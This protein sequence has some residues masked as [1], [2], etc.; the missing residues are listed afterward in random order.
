MMNG[1][2]NLLTLDPWVHE[3]QGKPNTKQCSSRKIAVSSMQF[4][5]RQEGLVLFLIL[6]ETSDSYLQEENNEYYDQECAFPSARWSK[7]TTRFTRLCGFDSLAQQPHRNARLQ[8]TLVQFTVYSNAGYAG[9]EPACV[10]GVTRRSKQQTSWESGVSLIGNEWQ[11]QPIVT[12][13]DASLAQAIPGEGISRT[14]N[15][16]FAFVKGLNLPFFEAEEIRHLS[17]LPGLSEDCSVVGLLK[18]EEQQ[19]PVTTT[20]VHGT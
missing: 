12:G 1:G 20:V 4:P 3:L 18:A 13:L 16:K 8:Q 14:K 2:E 5:N 19:V 11:N 6:I 15:G 7:G 10:S 17:T 9:T